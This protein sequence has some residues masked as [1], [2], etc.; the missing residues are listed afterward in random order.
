MK[1][2]ITSSAQ[3]FM[4]LLL[5]LPL[6]VISKYAF[7]AGPGQPDP[8]KW[9]INPVNTDPAQT[10]DR[11]KLVIY[12]TYDMKVRPKTEEFSSGEIKNHKC[13]NT[14]SQAITV[15]AYVKPKEGSDLKKCG[16]NN[17]TWNANPKNI[18]FDL[19]KYEPDNFACRLY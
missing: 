11:L 6:T 3:I 19:K 9:C 7:A 1:N 18:Y 15:I 5:T 2:R 16:E 17:L 10:I 12:Q 4:V 14:R 13:F 8:H